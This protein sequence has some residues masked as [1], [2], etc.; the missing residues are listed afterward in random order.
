MSRSD[1][2][3]CVLIDQHSFEACFVEQLQV[4]FCPVR[5]EPLDD[6][7]NFQCQRGQFAVPLKVCLPAV[8]LEVTGH[9]TTTH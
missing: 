6:Q 8:R 3:L 9:I 7:L 1:T 5:Q 2:F 4:A